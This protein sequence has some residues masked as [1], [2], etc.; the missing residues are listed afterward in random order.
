M[1]DRSDDSIVPALGLSTFATVFVLMI[2]AGAMYGCPQYNVYEQRL[3]GEAEL[4]KAEYSKKVAVQTSTAKRDAAQFEAQAEVIRAGGVAQ[5]NAIIGESLKNN[6]AYLKYLWI[7]DV[8]GGKAPTVIYV[9]TEANIPILEAGKRQ[10][11]IVA[12]D[13]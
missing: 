9:P 3:Q 2:I 13:K 7:T 12:P 6:E 11:I 4:A 8:A 1:S 10:P 5:A